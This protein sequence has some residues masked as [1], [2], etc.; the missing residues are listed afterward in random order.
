MLSRMNHFVPDGLILG[1]LVDHLLKWKIIYVLGSGNDNVE[2]F[3]EHGS[4]L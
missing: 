2:K 4:L 3:K 1:H